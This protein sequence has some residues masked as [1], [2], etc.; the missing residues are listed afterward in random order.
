[1]ATAAGITSVPALM[2]VKDQKAVFT[3]AGALPP[4]A[5]EDLIARV[6]LLDVDAPAPRCGDA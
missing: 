6:R 5:L 3:Q 4:H 2:V 1:M